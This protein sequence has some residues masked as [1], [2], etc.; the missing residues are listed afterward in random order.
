M[1]GSF[2]AGGGTEVPP[3]PEF[4]RPKPYAVQWLAASGAGQGVGLHLVAVVEGRSPDSKGGRSA[5]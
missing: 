2:V 1:A 5:R 3:C 4:K